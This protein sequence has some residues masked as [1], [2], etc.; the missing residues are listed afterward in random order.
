MRKFMKAAAAA[1]V[2]LAGG[3]VQAMAADMSLPPTYQLESEPMVEFGSGWYLRGDLSYSTMRAP[4]SNPPTYETRTYASGASV[5]VPVVT[6]GSSIF[7]N[8]LYS[9]G[10]FGASA[11]A[12]Y[13]FN[14]WF[15][16]DAT[17]DWRATQNY[18][19][20]SY[21]Q[22]C[23]IDVTNPITGVATL[24][25]DGDCYKNDGTQTQTWTS[26]MNAYG[27]LGTWWGVTPYLGA[28]IGLTH[29][30]AQASEDWF[31]STGAAYGGGGYN[32]YNSTAEG[33]SVH[34]GYPGN[35]GP[36]QVRTNFSWALMGGLAYDIAPHLKLDLGYRYLNMGSLS[37][38]D[39]SG[40][41]VHKTI[42]LQ[43]VRAGLRWTPDL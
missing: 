7:G 2:V 8:Q 12:G 11:G 13:Q 22:A 27:D 18:K 35:V 3:G 1:T 15:R 24:T 5:P 40:N 14:R 32:T 39:G 30:R 21:G 36:T 41:T 16:M 43:E 4:V 42:D 33:V 37:A 38:V 19:K 6:S 10:L 9:S 23:A 29:I 31:W 34:Y 26:L 28:G 17:F 20:T 25:N